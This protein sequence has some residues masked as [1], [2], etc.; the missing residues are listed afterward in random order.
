MLREMRRR[1]KAMTEA[2]ARSFLRGQEVG[3]LGLTLS[4]GYPYVVPVNYV[5]MGGSIFIHSAAEGLKIDAISGNPGVCFE[6][7]EAGGV[8]RGAQACALT[9]VYRSVIAF[10]RATAVNDLGKKMKVLEAFASKYAPEVSGTVGEA[11]AAKT[12]VLEIS[13]DEITGKKSPRA[14]D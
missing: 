5:E 3:R 12:L 7:D 11:S 13:I 4:N 6:V 8:S 2:D 9:Y 1:E 10:G 14:Q